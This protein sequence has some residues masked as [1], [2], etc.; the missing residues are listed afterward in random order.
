MDDKKIEMLL[1]EKKFISKRDIKFLYKQAIGNNS[2]LEVAINN[3]KRISLGMI[4]LH[5]LFLLLVVVAFYTGDPLQFESFVFVTI[6]V[7]IMIHIF[8]PVILGAKLFFVSLN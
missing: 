5:I 4:F 2:S 6:V 8:A 1:L 3:I 7:L